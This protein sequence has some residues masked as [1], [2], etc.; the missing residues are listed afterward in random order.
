MFS[1]TVHRS[2]P[3]TNGAGWD[4]GRAAADR[5]DLTVERDT[6]TA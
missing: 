4:A 1:H 5:A 2:V 6:I 3:V